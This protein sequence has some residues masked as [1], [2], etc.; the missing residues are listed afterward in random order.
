[1]TI[2]RGTLPLLLFDHKTYGAFVGRLLAP[3]F[4]FSAAAPVAYAF[5][6]EHWG[7]AAALDLSIAL[8]ALALAGAATLVLRFGRSARGSSRGGGR[9]S[10]RGAK[11]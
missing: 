2:T 11:L 3:S 5:V 8:A 7:A 1:M 10:A 6:I 9:A 4:L